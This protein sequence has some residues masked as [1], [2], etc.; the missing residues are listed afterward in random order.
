M[1]IVEIESADADLAWLGEF[2]RHHNQSSDVT[3]EAATTN[4]TLG[5]T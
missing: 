5:R 4:R 1:L 2:Y 3:D